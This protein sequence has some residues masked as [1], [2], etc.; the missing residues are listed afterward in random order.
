[1]CLQGV[2]CF[3]SIMDAAE[4][5]GY[6]HHVAPVICKPSFKVH[7]HS[8]CLIPVCSRKLW[9]FDDGATSFSGNKPNGAVLSLLLYQS[10]QSKAAS[11]ICAHCWLR[12]GAGTVLVDCFV[13]PAWL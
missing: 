4:I 5:K 3:E 8:V 12:K 13:K 11:A 10:A 1:M 6:V 9:I 7:A 2:I